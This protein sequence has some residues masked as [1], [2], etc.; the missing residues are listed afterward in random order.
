MTEP[1]YTEDELAEAEAEVPDVSD[2]PGE[3]TE[4]DE[5][6]EE[7]ETETAEAPTDT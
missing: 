5:V 1:K 7:D 6:A 4:A 2:D 3:D